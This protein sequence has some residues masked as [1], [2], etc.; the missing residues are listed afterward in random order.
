MPLA[1]IDTAN[2]LAVGAV[3][4]AEGFGL[5]IEWDQRRRVSD[6]LRD[7]FKVIDGVGYVSHLTGLYTIKLVRDDYDPN[8]IPAFDESSILDVRDYSR[9]A[10]DQTVNEVKV[11]WTNPARGYKEDTSQAQDLANFQTQGRIVGQQLR[12]PQIISPTLA[13]NVAWR[14]LRAL[15]YPLAKATFTVNRTGYKLQPGDAFKV[16]WPPLGIDSMVF[17]VT[18]LKLGQLRDGKIE[19]EAVQSRAL[20]RL[21]SRIPKRYPTNFSRT[22]RSGTR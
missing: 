22:T 17:R 19:V 7:V 16:S 5:N 3:L 10:W 1:D 2:F 21:P 4:E 14:E 12:F 11:V 18:K 15:S 6:F 8:T 9:T 13:A 20:R